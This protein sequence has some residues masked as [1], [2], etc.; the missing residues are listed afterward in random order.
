[1]KSSNILVCAYGEVEEEK[2]ELVA[3]CPDVF[4]ENLRMFS[5]FDSNL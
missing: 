3:A 2:V 1:M 5:M 4:T